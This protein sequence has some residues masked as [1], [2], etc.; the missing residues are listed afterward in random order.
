VASSEGR[1]AV[2][3]SAALTPAFSQASRESLEMTTSYSAVFSVH[4]D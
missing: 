2:P 3:H 4:S 1:G